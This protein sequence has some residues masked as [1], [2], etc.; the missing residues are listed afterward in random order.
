MLLLSNLIKNADFSYRLMILIQPTEWG[1]L[2]KLILKQIKRR[3][4]F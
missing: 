4:V 1:G 3:T 2:L